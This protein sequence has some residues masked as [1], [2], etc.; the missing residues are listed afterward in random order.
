MGIEMDCEGLNGGEECAHYESEKCG[1]MGA[2]GAP[3]LPWGLK[4]IGRA[5]L[6]LKM[7]EWCSEN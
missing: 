6:G 3:D 5:F 4:G 1:S 7:R 2:F